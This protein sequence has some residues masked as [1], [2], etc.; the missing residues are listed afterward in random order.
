M[1]PEK[2]SHA[3]LAAFTTPKTYLTKAHCDQNSE[4][5][6]WDTNVDDG[7]KKGRAQI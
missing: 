6:D 5:F 4:I 7:E 2:N 1:V 3:W